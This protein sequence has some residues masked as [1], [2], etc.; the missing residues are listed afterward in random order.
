MTI[1]SEG[2][3]I[4]KVFLLSRLEMDDAQKPA[5]TSPELGEKPTGLPQKN[6]AL[7][8]MLMKFQGTE[9]LGRRG[10]EVVLGRSAAN[11]RKEISAR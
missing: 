5:E 11:L 2:S 3:I 10:F 7:K 9:K 4:R 1:M 6:A 8:E